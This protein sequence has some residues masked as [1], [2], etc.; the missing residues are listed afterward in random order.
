M[1]CDCCGGVGCES[2]IG[3][4]GGVCVSGVLG[5]NA[6]LFKQ[7]VSAI[8]KGT[9]ANKKI[10]HPVLQTK[11]NNSDVLSQRQRGV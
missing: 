11:R 8:D 6:I 10:T 4:P 5:L 7:H 1:G 9:C 2:G 3:D